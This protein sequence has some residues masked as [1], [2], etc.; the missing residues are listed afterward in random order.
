MASQQDIKS[1]FLWILVGVVFFL[2]FLIIKPIAIAIVFGLL[3]AYICNPIFKRINRRLGK[4]LSAFILI[5]GLI[6]IIAIPLIFLA[7]VIVNEAFETFLSLQKINFVEPLRAAFPSLL[8]DKLAT[9]LSLNIDSIIGKIFSSFMEQFTDLIINL[10]NLLLQFAVFLFT[11]FFALRDTEGLKKYVSDLSPFSLSTEKKFFIEFR[12][13][14]NAIIFG[15]VLIGLIQGIALGIALF[16]LGIPQA[17]ILTI[18]AIMA[19][20]IPILGSWLVWLPV[21]IYLIIAGNYVSAIFLIIY[22]FLFVSVIDNFLRPYFLSKSSNLPIVLS[23]IGTIG[24][25]YM[26]GITGLVLG[27]LILAYCLIILEIY[28]Q[29]KLDELFRKR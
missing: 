14:T 20:I 24:G 16:F 3:F 2:A 18:I 8:N 27:P 12:G 29:G 25:L 4:N 1:I 23:V 19:S 9:T 7:P 28:K 10:T 5:I 26:F 17:L 21:S 15:Q 13:I 11:S 6:I 22:G